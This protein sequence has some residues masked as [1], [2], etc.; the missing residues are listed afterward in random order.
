VALLLIHDKAH[1]LV[2][3]LRQSPEYKDLLAAADRLR[4]DPATLKMFLDFRRTE[5]EYDTKIMTGAEADPAEIESINKRREIV[6]LN[7][8]IREYVE[9][10]MRFGTIFSDVQRIINGAV[11]EVASIYAEMGNEEGGQE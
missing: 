1:E 7:S 5:L 6:F 8:L 2:R 4:Q 10:E 3:A 11:Q 9:K